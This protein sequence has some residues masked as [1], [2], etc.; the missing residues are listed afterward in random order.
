MISEQIKELRKQMRLSQR[1]LS[2]KLS[3]SQQ[4]VGSWETG[5]S[6]PNVEMINRLAVFFDVSTDYLLGKTEKKHYYDL[7]EKD[8]RN[9]DKE[10]ENMMNGLDSKNSLSF[11][12]NGAELSD[13]D[14][15]LLKASMRQTLELSKQ[16]AK[17]KFTPKKYRHG[18]E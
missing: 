12:Q 13:D 1:E 8:E 5:R 16:L 2:E 4:T 14:K 3:V 9:I 18:E 7:T 15:E 17:R 6:E 11:F 10:L